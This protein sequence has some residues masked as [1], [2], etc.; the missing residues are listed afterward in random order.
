MMSGMSAWD[1]DS[2]KRGQDRIRE[3]NESNSIE[4]ENRI[5][6]AVLAEEA[7]PDPNVTSLAHFC[8]KYKI[9]KKSI[10]KP[11]RLHYLERIMKLPHMRGPG[12]PQGWSKNA[13][14][15]D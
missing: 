11:N 15:V 3:L 9:A 12:N 1:K 13:W 2:L 10:Q 14:Y 4:C 6:E 7:N 8:A 5:S